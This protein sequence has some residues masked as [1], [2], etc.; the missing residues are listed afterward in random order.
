MMPSRRSARNALLLP[1]GEHGEDVVVPQLG[2]RDRF[3]LEANPVVL[4]LGEEL[5]KDLDRHVAGKGLLIG[6]VNRGHASTAY[7][8][9][10]QISAERRPRAVTQSVSPSPTVARAPRPIVVD[11][12]PGRTHICP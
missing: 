10:D 7:L 2:D 9:D 5:G 11:V 8:L 1:V 12:R 4:V 6:L 3:D